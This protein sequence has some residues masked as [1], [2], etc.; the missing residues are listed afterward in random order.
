MKTKYLPVSTETYIFN[1]LLN[2]V[3]LSIPIEDFL[4]Y[5]D[6]IRKEIKERVNWTME[7]L[8]FHVT[9]VI[10]EVDFESRSVDI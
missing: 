8:E 7:S 6:L 10:A 4:K 1:L 9:E 3:A 2:E 5:N